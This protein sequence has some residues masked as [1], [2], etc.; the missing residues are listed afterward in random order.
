[1]DEKKFILDSNIWISYVI[2]D[3]LDELIKSVVQNELLIYGDKYLLDEISKVLSRPKFKKYLKAPVSRFIEVIELGITIIDTQP[4]ASRLPDPKDN[5]LIAL[6]HSS[7]T[8]IVVTGDKPLLA[9][10][11]YQGI[12]FISL[13]DF[14]KLLKS[15]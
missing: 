4:H 8:A 3:T 6:A 13:A 10:G 11:M 15:E 5:F 12:E 1:M 14:R 2:T 7:Q 9:L